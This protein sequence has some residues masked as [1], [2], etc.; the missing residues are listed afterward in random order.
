MSCQLFE[1]ALDAYVDGELDAGSATCIREHLDGCARCRRQLAVREALAAL[2]RA[3]PS[4]LAPCD[5]WARVLAQT[6]AD[7][8]RFVSLSSSDSVDGHPDDAGKRS[9]VSRFGISRHLGSA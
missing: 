9:R 5:L 7:R 6:H 8:E 1:A 4:Y 2:V 3:A